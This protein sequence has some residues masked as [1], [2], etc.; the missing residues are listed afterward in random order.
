MV[1]YAVSGA[2][3]CPFLSQM[4][5]HQSMWANKITSSHFKLLSYHYHQLS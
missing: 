1:V 5:P 4:N 2:S 3:C